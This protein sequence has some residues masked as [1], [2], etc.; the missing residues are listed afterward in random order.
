MSVDVV[1]PPDTPYYALVVQV[2]SAGH[3]DLGPRPAELVRRA[4][5]SGR[6]AARAER[7]GRADLLASRWL[8][9]VQLWH[10]A[11]DSHRA[12]LA[13]RRADPGRPIDTVIELVCDELA[14]QLHSL[15][16]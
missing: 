13:R 16:G 6:E 10:V 1:V 14:E 15:E 5:A 9:C 12:T 2:V 11:G 7:L 3:V 4:I 8:A